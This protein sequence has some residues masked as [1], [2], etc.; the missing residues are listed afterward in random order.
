MATTAEGAEIRRAITLLDRGLYG[1]ARDTLEPLAKARDP[2]AGYIL[3]YIYDR[4]LGVPADPTRARRAYVAAAMDGQPD[5]QFALGE[6]AYAGRGV[7][8]DYRR[9]YEWFDL[10]AAKGHAKAAYML[11][12]L[13][14]EGQGAPKDSG[15]AADLYERAAKQGVAAAM[16]QLGAMSLS[17]EGRAQSYVAAA[18]WFEQAAELGDRDSQYNLALLHDSGRLPGEADL[19]AAVRWMREAAR[20]M[21]Q[22]QIAMG[23]FTLR[24]RGTDQSD[25]AAARWFRTAAELGDAEGM[26]LHAAALAEGMGQPRDL[27]GALSWADR[28]LRASAG[29]PSEILEERRQLRDKLRD[30]L[31]APQTTVPVTTPSLTQAPVVVAAPDVGGT[32][33]KQKRR[34]LRR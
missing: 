11:G 30:A 29:E 7:Q 9:A 20:D 32:P 16:H 23:L 6:L 18:N 4:G 15:R 2:D 34:G 1:E 33:S 19:K 8:R 17:G 26:F 10:A 25:Q 3:G 27:S 31:A 5:A 22:A 13:H 21:P 12:V 14:A 28:S 24:G